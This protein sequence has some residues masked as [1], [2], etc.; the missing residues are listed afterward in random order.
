MREGISAYPGA[1]SYLGS[2][3]A[4]CMPYKGRKLYLETFGGM[5]NNTLHKAPHMIEIYNDIDSNLTHLMSCLNN[6]AD[7]REVFNR[8]LSFPYS[9]EC[10]KHCKKVIQEGYCTSKVDRI[11][12]A[13]FIWYV[14]LASKNGGQETFRGIKTGGEEEAFKNKIIK[15]YPVLQRLEGVQVWNEDAI[16]VIEY[17]KKVNI[18]SFIFS[19]SPY[20]KNRAGYKYNMQSDFDHEKYCMAFKDMSHLFMIC[21]TD[22]E[23]YEDI[24]VKKLHLN[25]YLVADVPNTMGFTKAGMPKPRMNEIVWTNYRI[26]DLR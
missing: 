14:L 20:Y 19:D 24:L 6:T 1:K 16:K 23:V 22:N 2:L 5:A 8:I 7:R 12:Y 4:Q 17:M 21:G 13:A 3:V 9:E 25:K 15:K 10:F 26:E 18:P 11:T